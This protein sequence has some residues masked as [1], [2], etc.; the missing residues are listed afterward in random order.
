MTREFIHRILSQLNANQIEYVV[1]GSVSKYLRGNDINTMDLDVV[2]NLN[3]SNLKNVD[4]FL[5]K[6]SLNKTTT[7]EDLK[8][9]KIIRIK[10][11]PFSFDLLP[12]L[13]GLTNEEIFNN[14]EALFKMLDQSFEFVSSLKPK[15]T[16]K[17]K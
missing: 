16:K 10:S 9:G 8:N 13:D 15:P 3:Q 12:R 7:S 4:V 11:F 6:F 14:Q 17:K 1:T 5:Q 2:I